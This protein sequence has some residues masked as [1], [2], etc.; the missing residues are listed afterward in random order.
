MK[1]LLHF[2]YIRFRTID[3]KN[4]T[5]SFIQKKKKNK[6]HSLLFVRLMLRLDVWIFF[7]EGEGG[8]GG[9]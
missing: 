5:H 9:V 8:F 6:V 3:L 7:K 1:I 2:S 4:S